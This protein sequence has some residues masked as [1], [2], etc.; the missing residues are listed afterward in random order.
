M[1]NLTRQDGLDFF[2][3]APRVPV[4]PTVKRLPLEKANEALTRLRS[5]QI[6]GAAVLVMDG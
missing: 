2:E 5:G 3:I 4:R 1:A 6:E